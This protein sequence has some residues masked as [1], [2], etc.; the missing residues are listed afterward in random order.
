MRSWEGEVNSGFAANLGAPSGISQIFP[1]APPPQ[2]SDVSAQHITDKFD[3]LKLFNMHYL[4]CFGTI[5][6]KSMNISFFF[7]FWPKL[8]VPFMFWP[9]LGAPAELHKFNQ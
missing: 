5:W 6:G 4:K 3:I 1:P 7:E 8:N 9:N 2:S